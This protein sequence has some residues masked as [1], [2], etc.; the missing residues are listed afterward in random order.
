MELYEK[1]LD[2]EIKDLKLQEEKLRAE[3]KEKEAL[4]L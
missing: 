1:Q 3:L 4:Y 2:D